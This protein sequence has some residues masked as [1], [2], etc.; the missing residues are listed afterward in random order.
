LTLIEIITA[1]HRQTVELNRKGE[2][3]MR[4]SEQNRERMAHLRFNAIAPLLSRDPE[5]TVR[6][7]LEE[8]ALRFYE[9]P[10]GSRR[11]FSWQTLEDWLYRYKNGGFDAL[12][13][14]PRG[15]LG[16]F[17]KIRPE[18]SEKI[19]AILQ[20]VP[21][22][23]SSNVINE[24]NSYPDLIKLLPGRT[25]LYRY[26]ASIR[27]R[28]LDMA[29]AA[30]QERRSFEAHYANQIWQADIMYGPD[31]PKKTADGRWCKARTYL[32]AIIDDHSRLIVHAEFSFSQNLTAWFTVLKNACCRHGI[33]G[34]LYC[35]N[36]QVFRSSQIT[37][38]CAQMGTINSFAEVRDAA[39]K[40]KIERFFNRVRAQFLEPELAFRKPDRLNKLNESF[41]QWLETSYNRGPHRGIDNETP[42]SRWLKTANKVRRIC[43]NDLEKKVFL[44]HET[45]RVSK[46][47]TISLE[48]KRYETAAILAGKTV[49]IYFDPSSDAPP[50]IWFEHQFHGTATL[51]DSQA[52]LDR[53]RHKPGNTDKNTKGDTA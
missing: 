11:R 19:E 35:D 5:D 14:D 30:V 46:T 23:K 6:H 26:I 38:I 13:N 4:E 39:A 32:I 27:G 22:L 47:G 53:R 52:N 44:F 25:T 12:R 40:G 36:G 9:L 21:K 49:N 33:P 48:S 28:F 34:R 24:L 37:R 7:S 16:S 2:V 15:D 3:L 41:R 20:D 31:I 1:D 51:L 10:D 50:N 42:H 45:S 29:S 8:R 17:R 43:D 18:V